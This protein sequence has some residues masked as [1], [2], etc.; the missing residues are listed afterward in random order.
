MIRVAN[1]RFGHRFLRD[2]LPF[3]SRTYT[4]CTS[5]AIDDD[6]YLLLECT[7]ADLPHVF[8]RFGALRCAIPTH[9]DIATKLNYLFITHNQASTALFV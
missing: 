3:E 9:A 8:F 2:N 1:F 6:A 7:G 4:R 5:V